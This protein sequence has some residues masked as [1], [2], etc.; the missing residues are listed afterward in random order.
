MPS[1][2]FS[3]YGT[4]IWIKVAEKS[5]LTG[6][7]MNKE[8]KPEIAEAGG[9]IVI[10]SFSLGLLIYVFFNIF[11]LENEAHLLHIFALLTSILFACIIGFVDDVLGWKNGLKQWQKPLLTVPIAIPLAAINAG[12]SRMN[13]PFIGPVEFGLL[14]PLLLIPVGIIGASNGFNMLAGLNG[15]EASMG[16]VILS[17][18]GF[19]SWYTGTYWLSIVSFAMAASLLGF[20]YYNKYPSRIFPGDSLTY[21][22]GALIAIIAILGN[23]EKIAAFV[24]LPYIIELILKAKTRFRAESFGEIN[25]DGILISNNGEVESFTHVFMKLGLKEKNVVRSLVGVEILLCAIAYVL[26]VL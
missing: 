17:F 21:G 4:K 13:L 18:L 3:L 26:F 10:G 25:E 9:I 12:V 16:T 22:I 5:G 15:L 11:I 23:L 24:F 1:F 19:V 7:D 6:K 8:N 2:L 14:Y 20:L